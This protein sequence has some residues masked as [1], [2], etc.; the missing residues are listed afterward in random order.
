MR[1]G[2][3]LAVAALATASGLMG[4]ADSWR[5]TR[6]WPAAARVDVHSYGNPAQIRGTHLDL[7]L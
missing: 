2:I 4:T 5:R 6:R 1:I 3:I 7:G